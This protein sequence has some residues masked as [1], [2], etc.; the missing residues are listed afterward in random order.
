MALVLD[1]LAVYGAS[2]GLGT[3]GTSIFK[4]RMPDAPDEC[5]ALIPY[6][7]LASQQQYGSDA[8]KWEFPRVQ[9]IARASR[10]DYST[11]QTMADEAYRA[12]AQIMAETVNGT[13]YHCVTP[14]QPPFSMGLDDNERPIVG[15]NLQVEKEL[16][17]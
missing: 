12:Y 4:G 8:L 17:A 14:L 16:S 5:L 11:A 13:F 3:V 9:V 15:F 2:N 6:G 1:D 7:G 10:H